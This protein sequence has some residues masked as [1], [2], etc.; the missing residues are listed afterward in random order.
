MSLVSRVASAVGPTSPSTKSV[1]AFSAI[2]G[3]NIPERV[4]SS[5]SEKELGGRG[6]YAGSSERNRDFGHLDFASGEVD[7]RTAPPLLFTCLVRFRLA[8]SIFV[9]ARSES[10][11]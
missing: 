6:D 5:S 7:L 8:L 10:K 11:S 2:R 1:C 3:K 4:K 9:R